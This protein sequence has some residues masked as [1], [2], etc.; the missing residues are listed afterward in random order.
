MMLTEPLP[1]RA[2]RPDPTGWDEEEE[3]RLFMN[4][5]AVM[6]SQNAR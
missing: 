5:M 2:N 1:G 3:G 4:A 6:G